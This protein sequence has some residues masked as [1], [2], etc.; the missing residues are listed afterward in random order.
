MKIPMTVL[1]QVRAAREKAGQP[2]TASEAG[3]ISRLDELER[4]FHYGVGLGYPM[5]LE[6]DIE[7]TTMSDQGR[8]FI[9]DREHCVYCR[10]QYDAAEATCAGCGAP[11]LKG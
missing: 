4:A 3:C 6:S 10:R 11:R 1:E 5:I 7:V 2:L 8:R 9:S